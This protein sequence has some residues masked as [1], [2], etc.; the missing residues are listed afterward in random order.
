MAQT[1]SKKQI[2]L[3]NTLLSKLRMDDSEREDYKKNLVHSYSN[4]RTFSSKQ[5]TQGE[6]FQMISALQN[7]VRVMPEEVASDKMR[8]KIISMF[9]EMGYQKT[10]EGK[11][12]ADMTAI[13]T[14]CE[15]KSYLQKK[16]NDYSHE[17]LPKLV[18][19]V[20]MIYKKHLNAI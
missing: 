6:A 15:H 12:K 4:G 5:L 10:V 2:I 13:H 19:Q 11:V 20:E 3:L 7:L 1:I 16:L 17:E 14:W 18:S 8:K 9:R